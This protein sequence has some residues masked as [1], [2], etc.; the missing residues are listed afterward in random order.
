LARWREAANRHKYSTSGFPNVS[1]I[2]IKGIS[3]GTQKL[4]QNLRASYSDVKFDTYSIEIG[5]ELLKGAMD[6]EESL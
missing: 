4:N 2:Y 3:K 6:L 1:R 5:N